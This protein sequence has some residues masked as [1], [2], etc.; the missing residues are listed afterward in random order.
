MPFPAAARDAI[1]A[2]YAERGRPLA[3]RR[4]SDPYAILVSEAMAQQTQAARAAAY[5]ERFIARFPSVRALAASRPADVLRAWQGLGYDRRALNLRRAAIAIEAEH[6]GRVPSSVADLEALPG[7]GP[8]TARA[9]AALAFGARVGAIDVNVRRVLG[10]IVAGAG[11]HI[12]AGELQAIAD[13]A[14]PPDRPGEWTHAVMDLGA[15]VC[16]PHRPQCEACPARPWCRYVAENSK[17]TS[18]PVTRPVDARLGR[19]RSAP[20]ATT[21]RWLRGRILDRLRAAPDAAWIELDGPIGVHDLTRVHAAARSMAADGLL[22]LE[23][24][25]GF[26]A[27]LP[28]A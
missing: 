24:A 6:G 8:Y 5:W 16:R 7:V 15:G 19:E 22:E 27:R 1:L 14:V 12:P 4:T 13:E 2:W 9:V 20:F 23:V 10:R 17:T 28:L 25:S 21:N 11:A 26:R 18:P 3:F